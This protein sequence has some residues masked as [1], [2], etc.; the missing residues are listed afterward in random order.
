[1]GTATATASVRRAAAKTEDGRLL[2][3]AEA[4]AEAAKSTAQASGSLV[5]R[6]AD[7][8]NTGGPLCA[9]HFQQVSV[10]EG[11]AMLGA[12]EYVTLGQVYLLVGGDRRGA[13]LGARLGE[14][15]LAGGSS[16]VGGPRAVESERRHG[17]LV[18]VMTLAL[19]NAQTEPVPTAGT[20]AVTP[21][22]AQQ[23]RP[24][25]SLAS[26]SEAEA[27]R[28]RPAP[29]AVYCTRYPSPAPCPRQVA[30]QLRPD[31]PEF[32]LLKAPMSRPRAPEIA[33][34]AV[35]VSRLLLLG[36]LDVDRH[37]ACPS[38]QKLLTFCLTVAAGAFGANLWRTPCWCAAVGLCGCALRAATFLVGVAVVA[39][40]ASVGLFS[41]W[42]H[43]WRSSTVSRGSN[44]SSKWAR[45]HVMCI[46]ILA[47]L[48]SCGASSLAQS[49]GLPSSPG[50]PSTMVASTPM[51]A[52]TRSGPVMRTTPSE[53]APLVLHGRH[54]NEVSVSTVAELT[55]AVGN[56]AV[57]KILVAAGTYTFTADMCSGSAICIDRAVTIEAQVPGSVVLDGN[58]GRRVFEIKPGGTAGLVGLNITGGSADVSSGVVELT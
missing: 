47:G 26:F 20:S 57:D 43:S 24:C 2:V 39:G 8:A 31:A 58:G 11:C 46:I 5:G 29:P 51:V 14:R 54:L 23:D 13:A 16:A 38:A 18:G 15:L 49:S 36:A 25:T 45:L 3:E 6:V 40:A 30:S 33:P 4:E 22:S 1:M 55:A 9:E 50:A 34:S 17:G 27:V 48:G 32:V 10:S 12:V 56:S 19:K 28:S 42:A 52:S 37:C 21:L 7:A 44:A 41:R 35:R 53:V